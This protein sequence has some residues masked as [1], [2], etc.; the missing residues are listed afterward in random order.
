MPITRGSRTVPPKPGIMPSLVSGKP[1]RAVVSA[2]RKSVA[3]IV[4]QPPPK[5]K[6]LMAD[7]VG[8]GKSSN[9][10]NTA[11][12]CSIQECN[13]VSSSANNPRNSVMS[14]PTIKASFAELSINAFTLG[15]CFMLSSAAFNESRVSLSNLL[16]EPCALKHKCAMLF[17]SNS[18][19]IVGLW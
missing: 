2:I 14:A 15:S 16:T 1:I 12:A 5:A 13:T 3:R 18:T 19:S 17:S 6:P 10:L 11:L 4:S 7:S 8:K 9:L